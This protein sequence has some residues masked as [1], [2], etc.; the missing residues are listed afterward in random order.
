MIH[1]FKTTDK[2][3]FGVNVLGE[4]ESEASKLNLKNVLIVTDPG[5][6]KTDILE[7]VQDALGGIRFDVFDRVEP[8]PRLECTKDA[9][10]ALGDSDGVLGLGGGSSM[11]IAKITAILGAHGGTARD[12]LGIDLVPGPCLPTI[13]LPTTSGTGSEVTPIAVVTV[14]ETSIKVGVVS[15]YNYSNVAMVDPTLT[16]SLPPKTTAATGVDALCHAVEAYVARRSNELTDALAISAIKIIGKNLRRAF[17]YGEDM[18]ARYN[19]SL[20]SV[21]A[22]IAFANAGVGAVHAFSFP[23]GATYKV[24]HGLANSLMFPYISDFNIVGSEEKFYKVAEALGEPVKG[25]SLI[26]GAR[27]APKALLALAEDL[28]LPTRLSEVGVK[29]ND[30]PR[31]AEGALNVTRLI[32]NNPRN[33]TQEDAEGLLKDAF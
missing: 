25:L 7:R 11:D 19:M 30:I 9:F 2:L 12:Y 5:I 22:G 4:L 6:A 21:T 33:M 24:P 17:A 10:S 8:E 27:L 23:L 26:E 29:E 16:E 20:G 28:Q 1:N 13:Q 15:P 14:P 18:H 3:V 32:T 31:L